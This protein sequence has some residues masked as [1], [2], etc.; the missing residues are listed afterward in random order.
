M[1]LS[2]MI[3]QLWRLRL[4]VAVGVLIAA[5][6]AIEVGFDVS[7]SPLKLRQKSATVGAAQQSM[8]V[9]S[10]TSTLVQ[11][12]AALNDLVGR[13]EIV[14]RL[15]NTSTTKAA[16]AKAM[17]VSPGRIAIEGP[18]P[19]GPQ[20]QSSE[21]SAQQRANSVLGERADMRVLID[22][23]PEAPL[24][25]LFAQ[26][27]TGAE[28]VRLAESMS[29]AMRTDVARLAA[30]AR[31]S[32]LNQVRDEI[33]AL[34]KVARDRVN[35]AGRRNRQR[36]LLAEGTRVRVLGAAT[37]GDVSNQTGKAVVLAVFLAI[38][39]AWCVILLLA[40]GLVRAGSR[41]AASRTRAGAARR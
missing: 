14:G 16:A 5:V 35:A 28:A 7:L 32:Q 13:A 31:P 29:A 6:A 26:A 10:P 39:A 22:T 17:G 21:P 24:I 27:P 12:S 36:D 25:T 23:D 37:G 34:P 40:A 41:S 9:D 19:N 2:E 3:R 18:N 33:A 38:I 20:F 1:E 11:H 30:Q 15:A 4:L 8:L